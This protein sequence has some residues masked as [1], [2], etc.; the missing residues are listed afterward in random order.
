MTEKEFEVQK[1]LGLLK[2]YDGYVKAQSSTH[3]DIYEVQDVTLEGAKQQIAVIVA[4]LQQKSK[5][6]LKLYFIQENDYDDTVQLLEVRR[7]QISGVRHNIK[8]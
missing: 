5:V 4:K 3:Y 8:S 6:L 7:N 2:T 1:A